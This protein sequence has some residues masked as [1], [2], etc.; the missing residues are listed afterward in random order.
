MVLLLARVYIGT[1]YFRSFCAALESLDWFFVLI[2]HRQRVSVQSTVTR[3]RGESAFFHLRCVASD[4]TPHTH[5][6][7]MSLRRLGLRTTLRLASASRS[8]LYTVFGLPFRIRTGCVFSYSRSFISRLYN[9]MY[10][11]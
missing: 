7:E 1:W 2:M 9:V 3:R 10:N 6:S 5:L 4:R 11:V 8:L